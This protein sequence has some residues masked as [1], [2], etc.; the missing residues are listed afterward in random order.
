MSILVT[1]A[2]GYVGRSVAAGLLAAGGDDL[3]LWLHAA[4]D[5]EA[6]QKIAAMPKGGAV[7]YAW[8]DLRSPN[9]FSHVDRSRITKVIH[10]AAVTRF[11]V[12]EDLA[13]KVNTEGTAKAVAF[14]QT[15]P[16][17]EKFSFVGTVYASGLA[18]GK[19]P[20]ETV[21]D[22]PKFSN[23]YEQSKYEAEQAVTSAGIPWN[24][25]RVATVI[26]DDD[27][28]HVTQYN[29]F[30]NTLKLVF[31]GLI[32]LLPGNPSTP[33]YFVRGDFVARAILSLL[34]QTGVFH[35]CDERDKA[36]TLGRMVD[37]AFEI[38]REDTDF[39]ARRI[40][41]PLYSDKQSF[42]TLV[43]G[44]D[45]FAGDIVNQSIRSVAPFASQ[46]FIDKEFLNERMRA[47][48]PWYA[49]PDIEGL[50]RRTCGDLVRTRWGRT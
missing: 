42:D 33:V 4:N 9:P 28:G 39:K 14:A 38:F 18:C 22:R 8:G 41:K 21:R 37:I 30:H 46:L 19:I 48:C 47:H 25:V 27:T 36:I 1:G 13:R 16:K 15:C 40:L 10:T 12:E 29:A 49:P 34:D 2:N 11:N 20:E 26:A 50:I 23:F 31:Y 24:I 3:I 5:A 17:L 44:L 6:A 35:L 32:S 43:E 7:N 45:S